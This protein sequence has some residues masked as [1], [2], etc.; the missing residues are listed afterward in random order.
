MYAVVRLNRFDVDRLAAASEDVA[1][2]DRIHAEQ[3]GFLG[4]LVVDIGDGGQATVNLWESEEQ[5]RAA[6]P[7]IGPVVEQLLTGLM[8]ESSQLLGTG[9]VVKGGQLIAR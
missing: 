1:E 6:L 9:E 3:P 2:F 8:A 4:S 7:A 5:A